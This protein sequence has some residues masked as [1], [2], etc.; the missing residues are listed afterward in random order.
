MTSDITYANPSPGNGTI[1][2]LVWSSPR[3]KDDLAKQIPVLLVLSATIRR[4][5]TE[6]S[7]KVVWEDARTRF[8]H[9][10]DV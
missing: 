2:W 3:F 1:F 9:P 7:P 6:V 4:V 8:S 10:R 5:R